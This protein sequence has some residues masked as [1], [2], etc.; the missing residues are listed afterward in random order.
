MHTVKVQ[1]TELLSRIKKNRD[2]HR[3]LFLSAQAGYREAVI[4]ELDRMLKDARDGKKISRYVQLAEPQDHTLDYDRVI[5]MLEMSTDEIIE[6][7]AGEFDMYVRDNWTWKAMA[8]TTNTMYA[9]RMIG[10]KN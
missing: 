5:D 7:G 3:D 10:N 6:I 9:A 2:A 4:E 8:D 1:R